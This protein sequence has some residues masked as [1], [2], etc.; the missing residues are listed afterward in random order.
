MWRIKKYRTFAMVMLWFS[1][2]SAC[3]GHQ[4]LKPETRAPVHY[5]RLV[6]LDGSTHILSEFLQSDTVVFFWASW[7]PKSR[8]EIS[9]LEELLRWA[10]KAGI[11]LNAIAVALDK[12][13]DLE[14][15]KEYI[16]SAGLGSLQHSF[17]GNEHYDEAFLTFGGDEVPQL[18]LVEAS[19]R[20]PLLFG[21][22][23]DLEL[24]LH[25]KGHALR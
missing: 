5:A 10:R 14:K 18:Y 22:V 13:Q 24:W 19:T 17:S 4:P 7:C 9:R 11:R 15:V 20:Q 3:S 25:E 8:R 6:L 2:L 16:H 23:R 1:F 21:S 12:N